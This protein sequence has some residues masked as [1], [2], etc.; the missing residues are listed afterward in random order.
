MRFSSC[1][2]FADASTPVLYQRSKVQAPEHAGH[3]HMMLLL[4]LLLM[5]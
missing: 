3:L 2:A 5:G 1:A 4:I